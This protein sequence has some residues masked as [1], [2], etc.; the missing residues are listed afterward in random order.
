MKNPKLIIFLVVSGAFT[1]TF[2]RDGILHSFGLY[3]IP[4]TEYLN[5]GRE[6]FGF[7]FALQVFIMGLGAIFFGAL[8]D[9]YGSGLAVISGSIL[10]IIGLVWFAN[11][12]SS[13]DIIFSQLLIGFG[14]AGSGA[15][16]VLGAVGRTAKVENRS[17]YLGVVMAGITLMF[18]VAISITAS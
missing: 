6:I 12:Q 18:L 8:S 16:V 2:I 10:F 7:A 13:I 11:V 15:S 14:S 1:I 17:F 5:I 9:K 4:I 3:L